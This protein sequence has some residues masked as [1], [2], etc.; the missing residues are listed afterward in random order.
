MVLLRI[1]DEDFAI[2]IP[3]AERRVISGKIRVNEAVGIHLM[4][5]FIEGVDLARMK[6]CRIQEIVTVRDAQRCAFVN[7]AVNAV[8]RAVVDGD[9]RVRLVQRRVPT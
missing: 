2:D 7:S 3:D 4:K 1:S 8:V 6:I 9:D 5:V